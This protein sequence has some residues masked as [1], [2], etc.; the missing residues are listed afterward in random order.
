MK[1]NK[2]LCNAVLV[3]NL[4]LQLFILRAFKINWDLFNLVINS[5]LPEKM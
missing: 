2:F 3:S 5:A 4:W 1:T